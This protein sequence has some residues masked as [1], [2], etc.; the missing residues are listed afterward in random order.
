MITTTD[1]VICLLN[2]PVI[3]SFILDSSPALFGYPFFCSLWDILMEVAVRYSMFLIALL[4]VMRAFSF[5]FPFRSMSKS[6]VFWSM[7]IYL[8]VLVLQETIP[9]LILQEHSL[10]VKER[11][12]C[13]HFGVEAVLNL[14]HT[15]VF[16]IFT[17]FIEIGTP[18]LV[19]LVT[20]IVC[21][22]FLLY[23][24]KQKTDGDGNMGR[25]MSVIRKREATITIMILTLVSIALN[26]PITIISL[27]FMFEVTVSYS[28]ILY[29]VE[30]TT[31]LVMLNSV[32]NSCIY[33]LRIKEMKS[34]VLHFIGR[35]CRGRREGLGIHGTVAGQQ[36]DRGNL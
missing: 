34:F 19:G 3:I 23:T 15:I 4:S 1:T 29:L 14:R 31:S 18:M 35:P 27:I 9:S 10:Y 13:H 8:V 6:C 22:Y 12:S 25:Q 36:S 2:L 16:M 7:L 24:K 11:L 33:F 17:F 5:V 21:G 26:L 20:G 28:T 32:A 30:I